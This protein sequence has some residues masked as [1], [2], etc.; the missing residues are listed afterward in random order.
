MEK[1]DRNTLTY[2]IIYICQIS[3]ILLCF[4][5]FQNLLP[6]GKLAAAAFDWRSL[7]SRFIN[8][9]I[10][11]WN[12]IVLS[13]I[14]SK[15]EKKKIQTLSLVVRFFTCRLRRWTWLNI[16]LNL[17]WERG[18]NYTSTFNFWNVNERFWKLSGDALLYNLAYAQ[19]FVMQNRFRFV[20][21]GHP[22]KNIS[23][24]VK[25]Q[26][27]FYWSYWHIVEKDKKR[28]EH[29]VAMPFAEDRINW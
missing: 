29:K 5:D 14:G 7:I 26:G 27:F 2:I 24:L 11:W 16:Y 18:Y 23:E 1:L 12:I 9:P 10:T 8:L 4:N 6:M 17:N 20:H 28:R 25:Y 13:N 3:L 22:L 21:M 15:K 19:C